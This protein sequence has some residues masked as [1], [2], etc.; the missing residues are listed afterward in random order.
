MFR[1]PQHF[2][3]TYFWEVPDDEE[4]TKLVEKPEGGIGMGVREW[5][6]VHLILKLVSIM[7]VGTQQ[8]FKRVE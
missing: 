5:G 8:S 2:D 7:V 1:L 4:K 3:D 6:I